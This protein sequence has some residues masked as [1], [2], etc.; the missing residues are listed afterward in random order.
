MIWTSVCYTSLFG[1]RSGRGLKK[2]FM[3]PS[4]TP[5][6]GGL[7]DLRST[8][9]AF[10]RFLVFSLQG[11]KI[12]RND[13]WMVPIFRLVQVACWQRLTGS[14]QNPMRY[15]NLQLPPGYLALVP[16]PAT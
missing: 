6:L 3:N 9:A 2:T 14:V 5:A 16:M 4:L 8:S 15:Q 1:I 13:H 12:R 7:L 11:F 10:D